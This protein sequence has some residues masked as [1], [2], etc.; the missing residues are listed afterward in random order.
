MHLKNNIV[1]QLLQ[2]GLF[3]TTPHPI[4]EKRQNRS[5]KLV[6]QQM[7]ALWAGYAPVP[8]SSSGAALDIS[9]HPHEHQG[10]KTLWSSP[11]NQRLSHPSPMSHQCFDTLLRCL[12]TGM[13]VVGDQPGKWE[14]WVPQSHIADFAA[15]PKAAERRKNK[16]KIQCGKT[17]G[18][19]HV[20]LSKTQGKCHESAEQKGRG[21]APTQSRGDFLTC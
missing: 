19:R 21:S 7:L 17:Q 12:I 4:L 6:I 5:W 8:V 2:Q 20:L 1:W 18:R 11:P 13:K 14:P 16:E 15:T 9:K 10:V 3:Q